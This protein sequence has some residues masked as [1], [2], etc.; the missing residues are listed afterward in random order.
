M[1]ARL[2]QKITEL[3]TSEVAPSDC[4]PASALPV[5]GQNLRLLT[6]LK[7]SQAKAAMDLDIGR[8]QY[9][10]YLRGSSFPKPHI[11]KKICDYFRVDARIL[12][13]P[14]T[15]DLLLEMLQA[16]GGAA[17]SPY[18][19]EWLLASRLG[20]RNTLMIRVRWMGGLMPRGIGAASARAP[21]FTGC[22]RPRGRMVPW[23]YAAMRRARSVSP[24]SRSG[25]TNIAGSA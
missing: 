15:E 22:S 20:T 23:S 21:L 10:R 19:D 7:G 24:E 14:L 17:R 1:N 4:S 25:T 9:Q 11:L 2:H 8:I 3:M 16:R 12:I 13:E 6:S 18:R 5:F